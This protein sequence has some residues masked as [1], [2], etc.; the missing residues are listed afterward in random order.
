MSDMKSDKKRLTLYIRDYCMYCSRVLRAAQ[1][2]DL[3]LEVRNI[4]QDRSYEQE[5]LE[6]TGRRMV[7]VLAISKGGSGQTWMPESRDIIRYLE[8]ESRT[9]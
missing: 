3:E 6:A 1:Q 4:W 5:L 2:L 7:P 8:S 9:D